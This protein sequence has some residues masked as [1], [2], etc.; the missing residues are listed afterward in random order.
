MHGDCGDV[1]GDVH[2]GDFDEGGDEGG[3]GDS[4]RMTTTD[5]GNYNANDCDPHPRTSSIN[6]N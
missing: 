3:E 5:R 1:H 6:S 2:D 4:R